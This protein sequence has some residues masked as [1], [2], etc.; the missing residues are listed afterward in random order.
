MAC[1]HHRKLHP[2]CKQ[3]HVV[4]AS[5]RDG[6]CSQGANAHVTTEWM[7]ALRSRV[8]GGS[9]GSGDSQWSQARP[10]AMASP[11]QKRHVCSGRS[12]H[13]G[14]PGPATRRKLCWQRCTPHEDKD[15]Q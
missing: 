7:Q 9:R 2:V 12:F 15:N 4:A 11:Q 10:A 14:V 8:E 3:L 13:R 6:A 1:A 5:T